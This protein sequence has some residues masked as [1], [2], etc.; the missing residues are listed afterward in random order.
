MYQ[1][2]QWACNR[3]SVHGRT[4]IYR[5]NWTAA[6][7]ELF[8]RCRG[9]LLDHSGMEGA[10]SRLIMVPSPMRNFHAWDVWFLWWSMALLGY[11]SL[12]HLDYESWSYDFGLQGT[13]MSGICYDIAKQ[14]WEAWGLIWKRSVSLWSL[15]VFLGFLGGSAVVVLC[16]CL[17]LCFVF[18][19]LVCV[20]LSCFVFLWWHLGMSHLFSHMWEYSIET[21]R[22]DDRQSFKRVRH[23]QKKKLWIC[24]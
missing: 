21:K 4:K 15:G 12:S 22:I 14:Y 5:T 13:S 8:H 18:V 11:S 16:L 6:H 17:C 3:H 1:S 23:R 20:L 19:F 9:L 7:G 10:S 2:R 24:V